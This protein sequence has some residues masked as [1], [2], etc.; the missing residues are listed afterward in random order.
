MFDPATAAAL[1]L[2]GLAAS[3]MTWIVAKRSTRTL[4]RQLEVRDAN[5]GR[6][7]SAQEEAEWSSQCAADALRRSDE[8]FRTLIESTPD[9]VVIY[10]EDRVLYANPAA[11]TLLGDSRELVGR[12]VQDF[13]HPD[14]RG[15]IVGDVRSM[16]AGV[17]TSTLREVRLRAADGE[18]ILSEVRSQRV[19]YRGIRAI[20]SVGRDIRARRAEAARVRLGDRADA[21]RTLVAGLSHELKNPLVYVLAN[22]EFA[23]ESVEEMKAAGGEELDELVE[24]LTDAREGARRMREVIRPLRTYARADPELFSSVDL[25][26][27]IGEVLDRMRDEDADSAA[28]ISWD[29]VQ[30]PI[31]RGGHEQLALVIGNL[32]ENALQSLG[33]DPEARVSLRGWLDGESVTVE[34]VDT[35]KG[36]GGEDL[37][38]LFDPFFTT[39]EPG[40]GAGLGLYISRELVRVHSGQL[41]VF[42]VPGEGTTVRLDLP[43]S[44]D[45]HRVLVI[46]DEQRIGEMVARWLRRVGITASP[47]TD[48]REALRQLKE[49]HDFDLILCDLK[50]PGMSGIEFYEAL[51]GVDPGTAQRVRFLTG[52]AGSSREARF[53]K[54]MSGRC[55]EKVVKEEELVSWIRTAIGP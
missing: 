4:T 2:A 36:I 23:L 33:E 38:R 51:K 48:A 16:L 29:R 9:A 15:L 25:A 14:D 54:E 3:A 34:I 37:Q 10:R 7:K 22:L 40:G 17:R 28:R 1:L 32:L 13:V 11:V 45:R 49:G 35:G 6:L 12:A 30:L 19:Q 41:R 24:G 55:M 47:Q 8:N 42:S 18:E 21:V 26:E 43:A 53:I 50:M 46:D 44:P 27:V 20:A 39:H 52:G 5:Q 31:V